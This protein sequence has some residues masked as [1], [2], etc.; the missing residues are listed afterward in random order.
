MLGLQRGGRG[1][2]S[3][4]PLEKGVR[5]VAT[6][7][8]AVVV[9]WAFALCVLAVALAVLLVPSN[10]SWAAVFELITTQG[11]S[12]CACTFTDG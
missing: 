6:K 10:L 2:E 1:Y 8:L 11:P 5:L 3:F 4:R 9:L 12:P 7:G